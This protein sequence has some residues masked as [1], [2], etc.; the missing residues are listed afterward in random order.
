M[1][2]KPADKPRLSVVAPCYNEERALPCFLERMIAACQEW[3]NGAYEIV[4]VNDGSRDDTWACMRALAHTNPGVVAVNLSRNHGHQLAVSAGLSLA[5]GER[6]LVIDADLQ[7]P[8]EVLGAMMTRMDE[9]ADVVYGRRRARVG[10]STFKRA[11]AH[12]FYRL[13]GKISEVAI[14]LDTGDFRLMSRDIVNRLIAM[15][16]QDRFLRGMVAW[17]GGHQAEVEYDRDPRVAGET[18]YSLGKMIALAVAGVTGFSTLP[19]RLAGLFT[20][21]GVAVGI[22]LAFYVL[23]GLISGHAVP[24]WTSLALVM[25]FFSCAQLAC[26]A[27]MSLYISRIFT[28][29][30]QRPLF[31]IHEVLECPVR[32]G[33]AAPRA[34]ARDASAD[35]AR[36]SPAPE[37]RFVR[38]AGTPPRREPGR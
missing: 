9:G 30:K 8:P 14:P 36:F 25:V 38:R 10:E 32:L 12:A 31:L 19:M 11:T 26:L 22:G 17:L 2:D 13:L 4:L 6:V 18:G 37:I 16:E 23:H 3:A 21:L 1:T 27:V 20:G 34:M 5:R 28:Q 35:A 7:D 33:L 24:G 15:P 29:V